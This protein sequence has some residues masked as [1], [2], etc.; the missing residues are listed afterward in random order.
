MARAANLRLQTCNRAGAKLIQVNTASMP[1]A[2]LI[3]DLKGACAMRKITISLGALA[4][5]LMFAS[6]PAFA[7]LDVNGPAGPN[8]GAGSTPQSGG[9]IVAPAPSPRAGLRGLYNVVPQAPQ[10]LGPAGPAGANYGAGSGPQSG[11]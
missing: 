3:V 2:I 1:S 8:Y 6:V 9:P 4:L 7:Q 11:Q 10:N 5:G